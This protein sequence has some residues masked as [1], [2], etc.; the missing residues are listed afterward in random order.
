MPVAARHG[1]R[2]RTA[3]GDGVHAAQY[4][5]VERWDG[6][7]IEHP[8]RHVVDLRV[9]GWRFAIA[10]ETRHA[11][12]SLFATPAQLARL[13]AAM[14][15]DLPATAL[16]T[17]FDA[18]RREIWTIAQVLPPVR[19]R[20]FDRH[21]PD[22]SAVEEHMVH[23][24]GDIPRLARSPILYRSPYLIRD[25][26]RFRAAA[27]ALAYLET[28]L[29][30]RPL[31]NGRPPSL[32]ELRRTMVDWRRLFSPTGE[33]YRSLDRTLMNLPADVQPRLVC[34]LRHIRLERAITESIELQL[35]LHCVALA[36]RRNIPLPFLRALQHA[37]LPAILAALDRVAFTAHRAA[38]RAAAEIE[39]LA[40]YLIDSDPGAAT[41]L[42]HV[43]SHAI[44]RH[45]GPAQRYRGLDYV[46]QLLQQ[47]AAADRHTPTAAPPLP[48]PVAEGLRLLAT[49][50]EVI[51]EGL[52]MRHCIGLY[53]DRAVSG[54]CFLFHVAHDGQSASIEVGADGRIRQAVGPDNQYNKAAEWGTRLLRGWVARWPPGRGDRA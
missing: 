17:D 25:V 45:A 18:I 6:V 36:R 48:P 51:D 14:L 15:L 52:R 53:A 46:P 35:L 4:R 44:R 16:G 38:R 43:V 10:S 24:R 22:A 27:I 1:A 2:R 40:T 30:P 26:R 21:A 23:M 34:E 20:L 32:M 41:R 7:R 37:R 47:R 9:D 11:H 29:W 31:P 54:D 42:E 3:P 13:V 19:R 39:F 28:E 5:F 49:V 8:L 12:C 50:G 33:T